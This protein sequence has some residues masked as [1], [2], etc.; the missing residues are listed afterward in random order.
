MLRLVLVIQLAPAGNGFTVE[1]DDVEETVKKQNNI[2]LN[3][4]GIEEH[5]A[6]GTAKGIRRQGWLDHHQRVGHICVI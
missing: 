1:N 6:R 3:R 2:W 5:W 4:L